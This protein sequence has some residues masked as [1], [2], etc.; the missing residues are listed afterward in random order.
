MYKNYD[1]LR[2]DLDRIL[3]DASLEQNAKS[4]A[5]ELQKHLLDKTFPL[6]VAE[7]VDF[8]TIFQGMSL[9]FQ[10]KGG[11]MIG[12]AEIIKNGYSDFE[13]LKN[14]PGAYL[15]AFLTKCSCPN[16]CT[17]GECS[18]EDYDN[19]PEVSR[20]PGNLPV[21][22]LTER[23]DGQHTIKL[24]QFRTMLY[25]KIQAQLLEY[26]QP[27][28][29]QA[30]EVFNPMN[31]KPKCG[32]ESEPNFSCDTLSS[33]YER[34]PTILPNGI[35]K[36]PEDNIRTLCTF[37]GITNTTAIIT[38]WKQVL[39]VII[40]DAKA[41]AIRQE[42]PAKYWPQIV[43]RADIPITASLKGIIDQILFTAFTSA[44]AER[45]FSMVTRTKSP[46]RTNLSPK[47][48]EHLVRIRFNG[49]D[50]LSDEKLFEYTKAF[51]KV[52]SRVDDASVIGGQEPD[53][54]A[55]KQFFSR[56]KLF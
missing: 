1:A 21:H 20:D 32:D 28:T 2:E 15:T 43:Q 31:F 51:V 3:H 18:L 44:D 9:R 30:F 56:S 40:Q 22:K 41:Q 46:Q 38:E 34:L 12:N 36:S 53:P 25:D 11:I 14:E 13:I 24:S 47:T 50:S 4:K 48:L 16:V 55:H 42:D 5:N 35:P 23:R 17:K 37:Y 26:F 8:L 54:E 33:C 49:P 27:D 7:F 6:V 52:S 45:A 19:C 39:A 10:S 29:L